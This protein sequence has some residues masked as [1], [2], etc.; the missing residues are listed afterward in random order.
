MTNLRHLLLCVLVFGLVGCQTEQ[1]KLD[2]LSVDTLY[3]EGMQAVNN[4]E[5]GEAEQYF[6]QIF[7]NNPRHT[8][9]SD[10]QI[11]HAYSLFEKR[12]YDDA[13]D[14]I[15]VFLKLYPKHQHAD[16]ML[17]L[18]AMCLYVQIDEIDL[19]QAK[20]VQAIIYLND[21]ISQYPQSIYV[22]DAK[23]KKELAIGYLAGKEVA[24]GMYYLNRQN[25][26][27]ASGRFKTVIE[28]YSDTRYYP[29]ALY[30]MVEVSS[31]LG[32]KAE[33]E[34]YANILQ[35]NFP[36]S[37]WAQDVKELVN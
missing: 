17:Y 8:V 5:Y 35:Q 18:R 14:I 22:E 33:V 32:I 29:E 25:P 20:T 27:A 15:D 21:V 30:R 11:M 26:I 1:K 28:N 12:D 2:H 4:Q 7:L 19:D 31:M 9:N 24:V 34:Y 3:S 37:E 13:V 10:A 16:Y 36:D 23:F 6:S